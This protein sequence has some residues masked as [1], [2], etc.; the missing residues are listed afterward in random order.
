MYGS[1]KCDW[2]THEP[3][4]KSSNWNAL[5]W[6]FLN[7]LLPYIYIHISQFLIVKIIKNI[8]L[9]RQRCNIHSNFRCKKMYLFT[10]KFQ[11]PKKDGTIIITYSKTQHLN[12]YGHSFVS[13]DILRCLYQLWFDLASE[14]VITKN[15]KWLKI[16]GRN[17]E[18]TW[19]WLCRWCHY[20]TLSSHVNQLL[21]WHL[22][23]LYIY[24]TL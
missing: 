23:N 9:L 5:L 24:L 1:I 4:P 14:K 17:H 20:F 2:P 22:S 21:C 3:K 12:Y 6:S 19:Y 13:L 11:I 7:D 8:F 16:E 18:R 15:P 10:K